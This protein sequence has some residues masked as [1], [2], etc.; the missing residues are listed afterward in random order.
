MWTGRVRVGAACLTGGSGR[1]LESLKEVMLSYKQN[2]S[3]GVQNPW[4]VLLTVNAMLLPY[5]RG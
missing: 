5:T 2:T 3:D 1:S 4:V